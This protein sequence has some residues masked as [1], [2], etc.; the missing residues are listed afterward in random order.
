M[1]NISALIADRMC[2]LEIIKEDDLKYY[3]YSIQVLLERTIGF[4]LIGIFALA[5]RSF[6]EIVVFVTTFI[7]IRIHSDGIHCRT[8]VGCFVSSV[9]FTLSTIPVTTLLINHPII[10]KE[11]VM[12]SMVLIFVIGTIRDPN[13]NLSDDEFF[14]LKI[15][16]RIGISIIGPIALG[17]LMIFPENHF[18]YYSACGVIYNALSLMAVKILQREVSGNEKEVGEN[19]P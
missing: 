3:A 12:F 8:S 18:V 14:R 6:F 13:L 19:C 2:K 11:A 5:F 16:S 17:L 1:E 15:R 4:I 9:L 10:C 7:L